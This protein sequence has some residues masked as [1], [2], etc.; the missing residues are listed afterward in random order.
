MINRRTMR[1]DESYKFYS[2]LKMDTFNSK[3]DF[4]AGAI[5]TEDPI[6]AV[7]MGKIAEFNGM[8]GKDVWLDTK[9]AHVIYIMGKRRSGKSYTLGV[10][11]EGLV[12]KDLKTEDNGQAGLILDT[13]N[14][15][16]A[17][18]KKPSSSDVQGQE[19]Q[20]WGLEASPVDS[21]VC[22]YPRGCKQ[23]FMPSHYKEFAIRPSDLDGTDWANLFEVDP[24]VEPMGQLLSELYEKVVIEGYGTSSKTVLATQ[25]YDV[26]DMLQCLDN[27]SEVQ[28]YPIQVREAIRRRLKSVDRISVFSSGGTDVRNLF[29]KNQI[30]V[31][32]L[33]DLETQ[34]RGLVIGIL[35]KRIMALRGV[36]DECEKRLEI[37]LK[38]GNGKSDKEMED[39]K[40]SIQSGLPRGW[41]LIDEAHN[42]VPQTGIIGSKAPLKKYV[43]EG[44][45][46]GLSVAVT[47]Q[48]PS[49]LDSSIRRNADVLLIHK[50]TMEADLDIVRSMLN[51][52]VPDS[53]EISGD[54]V[55]SRTF[56]H[57]IR[58]L[59]LGFCVASC[60]NAN[61]VFMMKV[62]PRTSI[63]GG[64]EF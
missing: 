42:Y 45:N 59:P 56:E 63:H 57:M 47:T 18:E 32:L 17:M 27:S 37:K 21:M 39:L 36:T 55:K 34:V 5:S 25:N 20:K 29:K 40:R 38:E 23:P 2:S 43:N 41:I 64:R 26:R 22:Y 10:I 1:F 15:Y 60:S 44:R 50:M 12:S 31:L 7:Y 11:A 8:M 62:R 53:I 46:M 28:R 33:R 51:T 30:A 4:L 61:R 9:A 6:N 58:E 3:Q 35:V 52:S 24:I 14:L 49:G 13:L 54:K 16:W 19:L 48:Q